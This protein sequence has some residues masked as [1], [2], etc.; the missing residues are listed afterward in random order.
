MDAQAITFESVMQFIA[1]FFL[2]ISDG[3]LTATEVQHLFFQK[4]GLPMLML[5]CGL[6]ALY[7]KYKR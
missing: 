7:N 5:M 4:G 3:N 2:A 1:N 6:M